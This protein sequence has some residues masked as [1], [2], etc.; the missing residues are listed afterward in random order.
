M[1][2]RDATRTKPY[3]KV[4]CLFCIC[5]VCSISLTPSFPLANLIYLKVD[6]CA[7]ARK[8]REDKPPRWRKTT[9]PSPCPQRKHDAFSPSKAQSSAKATACWSFNP[10]HGTPS[11]DLVAN[12]TPSVRHGQAFLEMGQLTLLFHLPFGYQNTVRPPAHLLRRVLRLFDFARL[13]VEM[14]LCNSIPPTSTPAEAIISR[15]LEISTLSVP[16]CAW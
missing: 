6:V 13:K 7:R 1:E 2:E 4:Q 8:A 12:V 3:C 5:S 15:T 16:S 14:G 10:S 11:S 9:W